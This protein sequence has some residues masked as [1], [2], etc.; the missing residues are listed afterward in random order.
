MNT[1]MQ[2]S[3]KCI[4]SQSKNCTMCTKT[5][6]ASKNIFKTFFSFTK[7]NKSSWNSK[8]IIKIYLN[9]Y[10]SLAEH[11]VLQI[12]LWLKCQRGTF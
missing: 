4:Y 12:S 2:N 10:C 11:K 8:W 9:M 7:Q 1:R 3:T 6:G 5:A